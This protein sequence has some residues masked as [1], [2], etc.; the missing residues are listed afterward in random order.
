[1]ACVGPSIGGGAEAEAFSH[2]PY[3]CAREI[4]ASWGLRGWQESLGAPA[5]LGPLG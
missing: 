1:M 3:V 5:S 4:L 2:Q